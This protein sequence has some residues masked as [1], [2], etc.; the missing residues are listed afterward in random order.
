LCIP[1][2]LSVCSYDGTFEN[3]QR[4]GEGTMRYGDGAT[5][6][7]QW[8]A[9][10]R[11]G[12]GKIEM[13]NG[14]RFIGHWA[15]DLKH[16]SGKYIYAARRMAY[17]G[18]W[19][20]NN[21]KCGEMRGLTDEDE[22]EATAAASVHPDPATADHRPLP[23]LLLAEPDAVLLHAASAAAVGVAASTAAADSAEGTSP[24]T[25]GTAGTTS[26]EA[27]GLSDDELSQLHA[28]FFAGAD[29]S[30]YLPADVDVL[31]AVLQHLGV[32][33]GEED[34]R[35]LMERLAAEAHAAQVSG[36]DFAAFA[37]VMAEMRVGDW[38]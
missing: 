16:G 18:E 21:A 23:E 38:I 12:F 24:A 11:H 20:H 6:S 14:D 17:I 28:A 8:R 22:E 9:G 30:G 37:A 10:R 29:E 5:Y 2:P 35:A 25:A 26:S 7:G 34:V 3:D 33:A 1:A 19:V 36:I 31:T 32:E 15:E 27:G 13:S 4:E